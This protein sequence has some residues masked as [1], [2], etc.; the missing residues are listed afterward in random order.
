MYLANLD[1]KTAFDD[2]E[3]KHVAQIMDSINTHGWLMA[4]LLREMLGLDGKAMFECDESSF[5]FNR[6]LRQGSVE[7]PRSWQRMVTQILANVEQEW[8]KRRMGLLLDF[9]GERAHKIAA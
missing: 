2:A 4:A 5:A 1:I 6:C 7:A 3:P 8:M 9:K